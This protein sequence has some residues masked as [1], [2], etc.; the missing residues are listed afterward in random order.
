MNAKQAKAIPI[1]DFLARLGHLPDHVR[2]GG[3]DI[4]FR[5]PF[6]PEEA[7]ASFHV[8][9][10]RN[11]WYDFGA[12]GGAAAGGNLPDLVMSMQR[13][14]LSDALAFLEKTMAGAAS[15]VQ[16]TVQNLEENDVQPSPQKGGGAVEP[17][18]FIEE[19][20]REFS[21]GP[22]AR[23]IEQER[24]INLAAAAGL[25]FE[26]HFRNRAGK[27]F[28]A[29]GIKNRA[30]GWE[31]RNPYFKG[32]IGPKDL[33]FLERV[34]EGA[35]TGEVSVFEGMFDFLAALSFYGRKSL[36][37]HDV[38]LLNSLA[39]Q[40]RAIDFLEKRPDLNHLKLYLDNDEAGHQAVEIFRAALPG[41]VVEPCF[42]L[43]LNHKDFNDY[44]IVRRRLGK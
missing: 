44:L 31:I 17:P 29:A 10:G 8:H 42:A 35:A 40:R 34:G 32:C 39:M 21:A 28:F 13:C 11:V 38:L 7:T 12:V 18:F 41:R 37:E 26:V 20:R 43:Y 2:H 22:L 5:S 6:R 14:G 16:E 19:I 24:Q 1:P 33:T 30:G 9:V 36:F 25:L 4:W 3:G 15:S 23:Y 27:R